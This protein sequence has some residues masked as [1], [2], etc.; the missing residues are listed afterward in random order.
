MVT[1]VTETKTRLR[2][3]FKFNSRQYHDNDTDDYGGATPRSSEERFLNAI[4]QPPKVKR[5]NDKQQTAA[6]TRPE[7][8]RT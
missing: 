7:F 4:K 3:T 5:H 2:P 1:G 6:D 8:Q